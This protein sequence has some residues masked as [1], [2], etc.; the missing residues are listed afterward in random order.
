M[1]AG[2]GFTQS[3][4]EAGSP[5]AVGYK[6]YYVYVTQGGVSDPTIDSVIANT[7]GVTPVITRDDVG[8]YF[9]TS[10]GLFTAGKTVC[11]CENKS[12][13]TFGKITIQR[14][15]DDIVTFQTYTELEVQTDGILLNNWI[16]IEIYP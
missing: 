8:N 6:L 9:I 14:A 1:G 13:D 11:S 16:R 4:P 12:A 7:T 2:S 10:A 15:T 5:E 3:G